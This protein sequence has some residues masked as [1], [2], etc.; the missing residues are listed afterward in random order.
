MLSIIIVNT[1]RPDLLHDCLGSV[2]QHLS[3]FAFEVIIA[4]NGSEEKDKE[5][6]LQKFPIRWVDTGYNSGFARA[7]NAGR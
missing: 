2:Y 5:E 4:S 6:L 1:F 3:N 7:N